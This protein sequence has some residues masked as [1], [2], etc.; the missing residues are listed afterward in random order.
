MPPSILKRID[1]VPDVVDGAALTHKRT[2]KPLRIPKRVKSAIEA[3]LS[4]KAKDATTAAGQVGLSR[5]HLSRM[6]NR[7]H[8]QVF[9]AQERRRTIAHASLR[10]A[11]RIGELVDTASEHVSLDASKH[12]L[13]IE[14]ISPQ[15]KGIQVNVNVRAGFVIDLSE[16]HAPGAGPAGPI[17]DGEATE[18]PARVAGETE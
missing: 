14:G 6:I 12:V 7:P 1:H 2:G 10:A 15:E 9:I 8:V 3:I 4:G 5:E 11:A 18:Q 16:G 13:A 17:V